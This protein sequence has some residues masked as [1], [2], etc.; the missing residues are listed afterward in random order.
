LTGQTPCPAPV[1]A[2]PTPDTPPSWRC[3]RL[4]A[5]Q[6]WQ[7]IDFISDLH[8]DAA[9]PLTQRALI[10]YLAHTP[11]SAVMI[12]GDLFEAWVGDDMRHLPFEAQ[13]TAALA[14]AGQRLWL[15][16]MHGNRD[17]LLGPAM[18]EACHAH[19][20]NDP[21]VL[22]AFGQQHLL[23]HGDAWCLADVEYLAFRQDVRSLA[24]QQAF[25]SRTLDERLRVA[26]GLREAS[27]ARK[28]EMH[29]DLWADVDAHHAGQ[30]LQAT[31]TSSLIHGHTHRPATEPFGTPGALRHVLSDWDLDHAHP[32][33]EVLR[34]NAQGL[35]RISLPQAM[36][37]L[38]R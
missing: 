35:E 37:P 14:Q 36:A 16:I 6:D 4:E 21:I 34:L 22:S 18:I 31:A 1:S 33:A 3:D 28:H 12:L 20:L 29:A 30:W 2:T 23:T 8:L 15:G 17:F 25:L 24:W 13:C 32:R 26:R 10:D 11:A 38:I 27:E 7:C 19:A 9:H 5:A